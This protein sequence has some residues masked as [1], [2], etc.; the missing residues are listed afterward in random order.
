MQDIHSNPARALT[1]LKLAAI[2]ALLTSCGGSGLTSANGTGGTGGTIPIGVPISIPTAVPG[3]SGIVT[4]PSDGSSVPGV[5]AR[6]SSVT[7]STAPSGTYTLAGMTPAASVVV[8]F[9]LAG[10][11]PQTRTTEAFTASNSAV[12]MNVP[13]LPVTST[14]TFDP[15]SA[16]TLTVPGSTAAVILDAGALLS[17][18][19]V[20]ATGTV[21]VQMTPIAAGSN[22]ALMPGNYMGNPLAVG[23]AAPIESFGALE[24]RFTDGAGNVLTLLDAAKPATVRIPV[25]TRSTVAR[26]ASIPLFS[27][28]PVTGLWNEEG[29][30]ALTGTVPNQYY[31]GTVT[32]FT[33]W[34]SAQFYPASVTY[35]GCV[36]DAANNPVAGATVNAEGVDYTSV[37]SRMTDAS[38]NFTLPKLSP[39]TA[40]VQA[41]KDIRVSNSV[42]AS[43]TTNST[44]PTCLVLAGA[45]ATR[46]SWGASPSD[47]D[48][49][50][51]GGGSSHVYWSGRG[52]L[53]AAPYMALDVDDV[54]GYGPEVTTLGRLA[55]NTTYRFYVH[56]WSG[57]FNP[58]MTGSPAKVE[59][60]IAGTPRTFTPPIGEA[61]SVYW[62]VY[63][64]T[65]D[66]SCNLT[67]TSVQQFR[68]SAP[69]NPNTGGTPVYCP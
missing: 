62:H 48:S 25:S 64:L 44:N 14:Q 53:T 30:A 9:E 4:D 29:T 68:T 40:I 19:G 58:G 20:P 65:T 27:F 49:H 16:Q 22:P 55:Q 13:M 59:L 47:L 18:P 63:D 45:V 37:I 21:T 5:Q 36:V 38:G 28:D 35:S 31:Q 32:H 60:V 1:A 6:A 51:L 67:L 3:I 10:Y 54:T 23:P 66:S 34:S 43:G 52:S 41:V 69:S 42:T 24:V 61:T 46:L 11:A 57:T 12:L 8:N 7:T 26:P 15:A 39:G 56:N 50:T 2:T 17:S 33:T